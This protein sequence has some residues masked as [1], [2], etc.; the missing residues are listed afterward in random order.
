MIFYLFKKWYNKYEILIAKFCL[1][2]KNQSYQSLDV[3]Y[4]N[5]I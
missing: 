4:S 1:Y 2:Y 3:L 5:A